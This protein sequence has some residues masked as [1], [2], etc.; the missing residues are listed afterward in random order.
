MS[1]LFETELRLDLPSYS[2]SVPAPQYSYEP[3]CDEQRLQLTPSSSAGHRT[4]TGTFI[5]KSGKTTVVL[6]DQ[7]EGTDSPSYGRYGNINGTLLLDE[8]E[9]VTEVEC[10]IEGKLDTTISEGG[11]KSTPLIKQR[12]ILWSKQ[13]AAPN[14]SCSSQLA[15]SFTLP[16]T[17]RD[18][19]EDKPLPPSYHVFCHGTP[20]LF[21]K[22]SYSIRIAITRVVHQKLGLW[23][24]TKHILI[25]FSY[26]PRS[27][28]HR[29]I[30]PRPCFFSSVKT[31]PEEWYQAETTIKR[32]DSSS[33]SPLNCHLFVPAGRVYGLKDTIPFHLQISGRIST[34]RELFSSTELSRVYS[35]ESHLTSSSSLPS[36]NHTPPVIRVFL[37]RQVT[38]EIRG[39]K[40][41]RNIVAGEG[42]LSS[43]PPL[44]SSCYS[45][46]SDACRES[47]HLDWE[48]DL[49]V[50]DEVDCAG[51]MV[52]NAQVKDFIMLKIT[53]SESSKSQFL[54]LQV[55]IPIR[56]VTDSWG[57]VSS[58]DS[59]F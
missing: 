5:K 1:S 10:K 15:F 19:T 46:T 30:L 37:M 24:K 21:L 7:E 25:P 32:R 56:L 38:V 13:S 40:S 35:A 2:P 41:W 36:L 49:R 51:F 39:Q 33:Q 53:P 12:H 11:G 58:M 42:A 18:G 43:V 4:P 52:A 28:A 22:T 8:S 29:P 16:G 9:T 59:S 23:T 54:D 17:F 6:T 50:N 26:V 34:L 44:M 45:P 14:G 3:A 47:E 48:G 55:S 57:D 20:S 31:S 27:R